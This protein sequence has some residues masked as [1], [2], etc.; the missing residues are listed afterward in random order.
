MAWCGIARYRPTSLDSVQ[1]MHISVSEKLCSSIIWFLKWTVLLKTLLQMPHLFFSHFDV[2]GRD[3]LWKKDM[4]PLSS[5]ED[6]LSNL[7]SSHLNCEMAG[8]SISSTWRGEEIFKESLILEVLTV[9]L[10]DCFS[11][12]CFVVTWRFNTVV[13]LA[14]YSQNSQ[15]NCSF[16]WESTSSSRSFIC[17]DMDFIVLSIW[18]TFATSMAISCC[19]VGML[20]L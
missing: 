11:F 4:W 2:C 1:C 16:L 7:H 15:E 12:L 8:V 19:L 20:W 14:W 18:L 3:R 9:S 17:S 13:E 5:C 6:G 10:V